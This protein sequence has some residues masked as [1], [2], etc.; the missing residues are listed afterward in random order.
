MSA[1]SVSTAGASHRSWPVS[2]L[3]TLAP[4]LAAFAVVLITFR[5]TFSAMVEIWSRSDTFAHAFLVPPITLWLAWRLRRSLSG[6]AV[7]GSPA[8]LV[9]IGAACLLWLLGQLAGVAAATQ[10]AAVAVLVLTV[11]AVL[12]TAVARRLVFPLL[13]LFFCVPIGDFLVDPMMVATADFTVLAL[14]LSG[15]P[16]YR[17]GLTFVIP[18]GNWSVVEACSGVR[19]LIASFMVGTLFAHLNFRS[20]RRQLLFMTFSLLVPILANWVRAYIIVMLGHLSGNK[21]AVGADHLIYGWLFF[22]VVIFIM[23]AIGARFA[24]VAAPSDPGGYGAPALQVAPP[25]AAGAWRQARSL[26]LAAAAASVVVL[27]AQ[28]A[29]W[30]LDHPSGAGSVRLELPAGLPGGWAASEMRVSSWSPSYL[31]PSAVAARTYRNGAA[32]VGVWIGYYRDQGFERKL[33]TSTNVLVP[34]GATD[35]L[36]LGTTTRSLRPG[37]EDKAAVTLRASRL[38]SPADLNVGAQHRLLV[39]QVYRFGGSYEHADARAKLRLALLRLVGRSDDS[40]VLMFFA[41]TDERGNGAA[42]L[43][44]FVSDHLGVFASVVDGAAAVR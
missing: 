20:R 43:E 18:S 35:W 14:R 22:G 9:P 10:F 26:W 3:P 33:I 32:A 39:L 27:V 38:R 40:A 37:G 11:P 44:R 16:V 25:Q 8:W 28:A 21:L 19:Y 29:W 7:A 24:D 23:F 31:N 30:R 13:F 42:A 6:V 5:G 36:P 1:D 15:I 41:E 12:G 34:Q 2:A 4:L 17:E